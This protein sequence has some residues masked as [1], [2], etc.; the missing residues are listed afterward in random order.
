[1]LGFCQLF[2]HLQ[3][4]AAAIK[5]HRLTVSEANGDAAQTLDGGIRAVLLSGF[6]DQAPALTFNQQDGL[7][8]AIQLSD[9]FSQTLLHFFMMS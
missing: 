6:G 4:L 3:E 1:M 7:L 8:D 9:D 2:D 5:N